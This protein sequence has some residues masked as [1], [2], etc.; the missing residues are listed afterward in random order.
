MNDERY[1]A[2]ELSEL[3]DRVV[4]HGAEAIG[5]ESS[6]DEETVALASDL[7]AM[8]GATPMREGFARGLE[9]RLRAQPAAQTSRRRSPLAWRHWVTQKINDLRGGS[10][11]R[12]FR[13]A[14]GMP[15][16]RLGWAF[17]ALV[18]CLAFGAV[19][20][21]VVPVVSRLFQQEAGLR[22][23]EQAN[24]VQELNLSQTVDGVTV[25]LER[26]YADANRIV[27]GFTIKDPNGQRYDA[28]HLTLTDAAG[29]V[30][31]GMHGYGVTG[32]SDILKVSLPPGEGAYV[33]AFDAAPVEG[34]PAE[35]DLRLV[36]EVRE[37]MLPLDAPEP[38][39][40]PISPPDEPPA[41]MVVEALPVPEGAIVGIFTF[42]FSVPFI[43]GRVAEVNQTVEDAGAAVCL[44][45]VVVTPSETRAYLRFDSPGGEAEWIPI[46]M[47]QAPGEEDKSYTGYVGSYGPASYQYGFL[48]PLYERRGEWTLTVTELVGHDIERLESQILRQ[49]DSAVVSVDAA[50]FQIRLAGPWVFCFRV[51]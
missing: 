8:A 36:M 11:R 24:L 2:D 27:V 38:P 39:P 16:T 5:V 1:E 6:L 23:V 12:P 18:L 10:T 15:A 29:A 42:D 51:P 7:R 20:Y 30:F 40:T 35:L 13:W 44:E 32:Q 28:S 9:K 31:S 26:A 25:T 46:A 19:A 50:E 37:F 17:M 34:A 14:R 49:A 22:H 43:P 4:L 41:S 45:R 21:A 48:A 3:I 33:L 47:L